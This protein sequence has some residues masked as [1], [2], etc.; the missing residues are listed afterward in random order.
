MNYECR[1]SIRLFDIF[2]TCSK[3]VFKKPKNQN[4][5]KTAAVQL[6]SSCWLFCNQWECEEKSV[7]QIKSC[8]D[9]EPAPD[10]FIAKSNPLLDSS[11]VCF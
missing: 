4:R 10:S 5:N 7:S 8:K 6:S 11:K 1:Y 9:N 2:Q 3:G